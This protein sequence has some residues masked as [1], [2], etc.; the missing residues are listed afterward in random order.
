MSVVD[1]P[2][3]GRA[4]PSNQP[5]VFFFMHI[6]KTAGSFV[7]EVF[8]SALG[9][10]FVEH[11]EAHGRLKPDPDVMVWSGHVYL[12]NWRGAE[13]RFGWSTKRVT[14]LREPVSQIASHILWLDHYAEPAQAGAYKSLD[15][16]SRDVV[17]AIA[18]TDLSDAGD[19][20]RLL[21]NLRDR[22]IM[23]LDNCQSRYF[24]GGG[25]GIQRMEPMHLG[26]RGKLEAAAKEFTLIGTG[27]R[28]KDFVADVSDLIGVELTHSEKRVNEARSSRSID[29][30]NPDIRTVLSKRTTLDDWLYRSVRGA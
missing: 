13:K 12:E 28:L 6:A 2:E 17:D 27:D 10:R 5:N 11:C 24:I 29:L 30:T 25:Q 22:G 1:Q 18:A 16:G 8:K 21:V 7:N 20:D 9:D 26:M 14:L 3:R 4:G 19:I 15:P 23:Y